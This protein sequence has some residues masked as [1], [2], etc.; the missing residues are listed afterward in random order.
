[1]Q[2]RGLAAC[3][4]FFINLRGGSSSPEPDVKIMRRPAAE[5]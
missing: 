5:E 2:A 3:V 4:F 1:L